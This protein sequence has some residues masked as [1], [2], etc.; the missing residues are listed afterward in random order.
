MANALEVVQSTFLSLDAQY[1]MLLS[2]CQ[3]DSDRQ[4]LA[5]QY[6]T[7]ML[8]Y[9]TALNNILSDNDAQVKEIA[10]KLK[11]A[12]ELV[13]RAT[14]Q[15]GQI[16]TVI[17]NITTAVALGSQLIAKASNPILFFGPGGGHEA[18]S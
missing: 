13:V 14:S 12:N 6:A 5:D 4:A 15:L 18:Q 7:A 1:N 17:D 11:A 8:N 9:Q 10:D 16:S 2:G 3:T